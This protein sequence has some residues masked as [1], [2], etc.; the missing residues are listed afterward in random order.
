MTSPLQ[1]LTI[2]KDGNMEEIRR[3]FKDP[4][5]RDILNNTSIHVPDEHGF[6]WYNRRFL[7]RALELGV[8]LECIKL[9]VTECGIDITPDAIGIARQRPDSKEAVPLLWELGATFHTQNCFLFFLL[10]VEENYSKEVQLQC[11]ALH[12]DWYEIVQREF[13]AMDLEIDR[14]QR[15][16]QRAAIIVLTSRE[17]LGI[18][19]D[20]ANLIAKTMA[21]YPVCVDARWK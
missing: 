2:L 1:W 7:D 15:L 3:F 16:A 20:L 18:S 19:K 6:G 12:R 13:P 21:S 5:S 9:L 4:V 10:W 17:R 11:A 8:N 14:R